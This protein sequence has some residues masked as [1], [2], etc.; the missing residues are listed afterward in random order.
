MISFTCGSRWFGCLPIYSPFLGSYYLPR[1]ILKTVFP[2]H[3]LPYLRAFLYAFRSQDI[4]TPFPFVLLWFPNFT[5][6]AL[7]HF[8][9]WLFAV[10]VVTHTCRARLILR[11]RRFLL[12]PACGIVLCLPF[13]YLWLNPLLIVD[14]DIPFLPSS[15]IDPT[16]F[17]PIL[18]PLHTVCPLLHLTCGLLLLFW[19]MNIYL[20]SEAKP[21]YFYS[22]CLLPACPTAMPMPSLGGGGRGRWVVDPTVLL[23]CCCDLLPGPFPHLT[24][25]FVP[26]GAL[27]PVV[28]IWPLPCAAWLPLECCL[29]DL[30]AFAI[31]GG[32]PAS[33]VLFYLFNSDSAHHSFPLVVGLPPFLPPC[34]T[35]STDHCFS[36]FVYSCALT[37]IDLLPTTC[38]LLPTIDTTFYCYLDL[39][40]LPVTLGRWV[41]ALLF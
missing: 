31:L 19:N 14:N 35:C 4:T 38:W 18:F 20:W 28:L 26:F 36:T 11:A 30:P 33:V 23:C 37:T 13:Y 32:M 34:A 8:Y 16:E 10:G 17:I 6:Y 1:T 2:Y 9:T 25:T 12:R 40:P 27:F 7:P 24:V 21:T 3:L 15:A 22:H 41:L 39:Y 29:P 5:G